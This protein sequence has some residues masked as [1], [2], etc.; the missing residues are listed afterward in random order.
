[1]AGNRS[2]VSGTGLGLVRNL[3][4]AWPNMNR[5]F[6]PLTAS[7]CFVLVAL[8]CPSSMVLAQN[9][10]AAAEEPGLPEGIYVSS[11]AD[12]S[13]VM[14]VRVV[15]DLEMGT[16]IDRVSS[17]SSHLLERREKLLPDSA[18][19]ID[20]KTAMTPSL[21]LVRDALRPNERRLGAR[22]DYDA[23]GLPPG[24]PDARTTHVLDLDELRHLSDC[25]RFLIR[26]ITDSA[27]GAGETVAFQF[28]SRSGF[29]VSLVLT[30]GQD[31]VA[32]AAT[33]GKVTANSKESARKLFEDS[34]AMVQK[35][36]QQLLAL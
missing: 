11:V 26:A 6:S 21:I 5:T 18:W 27:P 36:L 25:L 29:T 32:V 23:K 22:L 9:A 30:P 28:R 13:K 7:F 17:V 19:L 34:G 20:A 4:E 10:A 2:G 14:Q 12:P 1:M 15:R 8:L 31:G 35:V 16:E 33:V 3:T 24:S